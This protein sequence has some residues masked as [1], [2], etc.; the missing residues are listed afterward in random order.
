MGLRIQNQILV[1]FSASL[2]ELFVC[3]SFH[4]R[5]FNILPQS[6]GFLNQGLGVMASLHNNI[7]F[8]STPYIK[9]VLFKNVRY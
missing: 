4:L 2:E 7:L 1:A 5:I 8:L 3:V 6:V 9:K